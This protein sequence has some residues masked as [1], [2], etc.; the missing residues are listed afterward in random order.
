MNAFRIP[1]LQP[2]LPALEVLTPDFHRIWE[3]RRFS[4]A[5]H[6]DQRLAQQLSAY[7]D[8]A[9]CIPVANATLGLMLAAKALAKPSGKRQVAVLPSFTFPASALALQWAGYEPVFCDID[10]DTLQPVFVPDVIRS[11]SRDVG[12]L[13]ACNTFG[14]PGDLAAWEAAAAALDVPLLID[15]ASGLGSVYT[16][17]RKLGAA[18]ATEVFS[19]HATKTFGVGEGGVVATSDD[20]LAQRLLRARNFGLDD[21][22]VCIDVGLNA[23]LAEIHA[24]IACHVLA[25]YDAACTQRRGI[26]AEYVQRLRPL[27]VRFQRHGE[28]STYQCVSALLPQGSERSDVQR[29]LAQRGIETRAYFD[30][31]LHRHPQFHDVAAVNSL[32]TTNDVAA[33]ILSLPIY[34]DMNVATVEEVCRALGDAL[35]QTH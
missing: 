4:N 3:T 26:A 15:S 2:Q 23:K 11:Q 12:L 1:F 9:H 16:D 33:R 25:G 35:T 13:L 22:G 19:L 21:A 29:L 24:A 8:G 5:G 17:G 28:R 30:P 10:A 32:A 7:L 20:T 18:G 31:P 14:A 34:N 6:F 27:G